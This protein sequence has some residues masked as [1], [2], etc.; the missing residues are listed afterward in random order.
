MTSAMSFC[1]TLVCIPRPV[2]YAPFELECNGKMPRKFSADLE[3]LSAV[4]YA[5]LA[6]TN[7]QNPARDKR[8]VRLAPEKRRSRSKAIVLTTKES[9]FWA[10]FLASVAESNPEANS[11]LL[12][13]RLQT[14]IQQFQRDP[15]G[16]LGR[17]RASGA[18]NVEISLFSYVSHALGLQLP[19][20]KLMAE[21]QR[22]YRALLDAQLIEDPFVM[23]V[24]MISLA[25]L[26]FLPVSFTRQTAKGRTLLLKFETLFLSYE[27]SIK[28]EITTVDVR[29][30]LW[31]LVRAFYRAA[32]SGFAGAMQEFSQEGLQ[33][34][35]DSDEK[36]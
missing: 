15:H 5:M 9:Y 29:F 8:A 24:G 32:S 28:E 4:E 34:K 36:A 16:E 35:A 33:G 6:L 10:T 13:L 14:A 31:K 17:L 26:G 18:D 22:G 2:V 27:K 7:Q 25:V 20:E 1:W 23:P 19:T 11:D 3:R 12:V 21:T 30:R